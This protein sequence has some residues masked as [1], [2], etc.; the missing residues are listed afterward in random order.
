[1]VVGLPDIVKEDYKICGLVG[2]AGTTLK[3]H[4]DAFV[5][6]LILDSLRGEDST[7]VA[8]VPRS[9]NAEA[10]VVKKVGDPFQL[11]DSDAF[12]TGLNR[13]N[14]VLIGHNRY[15]TVGTVSRKTAHPFE[16]DKL[17]GVHNGTL[18]N[19]W[20]LHEGNKFEV[21]SQ[22][23]YHHIQEKGLANAIK[24]VK[25]A[26]ALVWWDKDQETL[27]FLRNDQRPLFMAF[28]KDNK[29]LMWASEAWMLSVASSRRNIELQEIKEL[30]INLHTCFEIPEAGQEF[31]KPKVKE[32]KQ[33]PPSS[34]V[35][36]NFPKKEEEDAKKKSSRD[37]FGEFLEF[38]VIAIA[39][40]YGAQYAS[41][42]LEEDPMLDVRLYLS[43]G[44][45]NH[46]TSHVGG[47]IKGKINRITYNRGEPIYKIAKDSV[48]VIPLLIEGEEVETRIDH[49]GCF[50]TED[51]F[52]ARYTSCAWCSVPLEF[53][54][55]ESHIFSEK[56][57]VCGGC[58][59]DEEVKQYLPMA[60]GYN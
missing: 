1:M 30:P 16:L 8:F 49:K 58:M 39:N 44:G 12:K 33:S 59:S 35:A 38:R 18:K 60:S 42:E 19:K 40:E 43:W 23:L 55:K 45:E 13:L 15:A 46:I 28:A 21:D 37:Y 48:E 53:S 17:I 27:N 6:M 52:N 34:V 56:D 7:G 41:L 2:V 50:L 25:G 11:F 26:Y 3:A 9:P 32:I 57:C 36:G 31:S 51:E 4:D 24:T 10:S 54:D 14:K 22:A 29:T 47:F 5:D 20:E